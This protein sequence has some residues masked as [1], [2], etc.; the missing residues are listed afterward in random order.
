MNTEAIKPTKEPAPAPKE[1]QSLS[2]IVPNTIFCTLKDHINEIK[3][4]IT[5]T[6]P[7]IA[8]LMK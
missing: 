2:L 3:Q 6:P 1:Y 5:K 4:P 7:Y 8:L